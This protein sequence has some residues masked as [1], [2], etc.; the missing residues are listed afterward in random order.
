[1]LKK[2]MIAVVVA[3]GAF[4]LFVSTRPA[5]YHVERSRTIAAPVEVVFALVS[6]L[7]A[8]SSWSPWQKLDPNMKSE[9]Q[10]TAGA[11]GQRYHWA[12][13]DDVGEGNMTTTA[14]TAPSSV[15]QNLEFLR[16][17]ASQST[18]EFRLVVDGGSATKTTWTMNGHNN[19]MSKMMS[20]FLNMDDLIGKD[21]DE[22]LANLE[23][24]AKLAFAKAEALALQKQ[25]AADA[26]AA[27]AA[28]AAPVTPSSP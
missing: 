23:V 26:A 19:F 21:C 9:L 2:T 24:Q 3:L 7:S 18:V 17:F 20:I 6:D 11:V 16:P 15:S 27:A 12:G 14:L 22:G 8:F 13:N 1:M 28:A 10:G 25:A 4:F 5:I